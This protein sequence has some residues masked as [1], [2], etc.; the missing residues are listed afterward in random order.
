MQRNPHSP[1]SHPS[2]LPCHLLHTLTIFIL[3][4][5]T[6]CLPIDTVK[7]EEKPQK[8][9]VPNILFILA[10]DQGTLDLNCYGS[11]DLHT[12][13]LDALAQRG[14]RFTQFYVGAPVCSPSRAALLTGRYPQR[15]GVPGNVSSHKGH[16]GMPTE[17]VTLAEVL[18]KAGY[19]TALFGKWHL[20][21]V[22]E[23]SPNAQGFDEFFGHK[24]GCID[25][26]SHFFYWRPPHF[27]DLHRNDKEV[28]ENGRH[29]ARLITREAK[30]FIGENRDRPFFLF[31]PFNIPHYPLQSFE[32][33]RKMYGEKKMTWERREYAALVST[34]DEAVGEVLDRVDELGLRE[35]TMVVFL[36]DHG[37]STEARANFRGGNAGPY[38]GWK[39]T[40]WEGGIRV[41]CI[42]SLPGRIPSGQRRDQIATS[43]DW[44]PTICR[45]C[46][47][48]LPKRKIDGRDITSLIE[49]PTAK[50]PHDVFHWLSG[51]FWAVRRG[52]WKLV[53]EK[54]HKKSKAKPALFLSDM[55]KDVTET[56][57]L[58]DKYPKIVAELSD[59]HNRWAKEV[60]S[61]AG[62]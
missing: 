45:Y 44:F 55:S 1:A 23:C 16:Q 57:N 43:L 29:F 59:L 11:K 58:A 15:A 46:N 37:H 3:T 12:P 9:S 26:W 61:P 32:K 24:A 39:F 21:T 19:R 60:A 2:H 48:E 8:R 56:K 33:Y 40:V 18:Q 7:C 35:N 53:A 6:L 5:V 42:V 14:V 36:S 54:K 4:A 51:K 30:R 49:S 20:G 31:M 28:Y 47:V 13:N 22:P 17:Q 41:P 52:D 50:T 62:K 38:R 34:M 25:N 10:D 27:H